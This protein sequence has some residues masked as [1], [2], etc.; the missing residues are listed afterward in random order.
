MHVSHVHS[1]AGALSAALSF[2]VDVTLPPALGARKDDGREGL[3]TVKLNVWTGR[4]STA[5]LT[6]CDGSG[7][8][9]GSV[10]VKKGS[11]AL[12]TLSAE[13]LAER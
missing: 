10:K 4:S 11:A 7:E 6:A 9:D 2:S 5:S 1:A 3:R 13:S 12:S 8:P